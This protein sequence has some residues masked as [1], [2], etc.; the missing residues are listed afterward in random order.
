MKLLINY[1]GTKNVY[2]SIFENGDSNDNTINLLKQFESY[3]NNLK[4]INKIVTT[5]ITKKGTKERIEYLTELRNL[6][7]NFIYFV[8]PR[9]DEN[10]IK[11]KNNPFEENQDQD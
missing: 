2:I 5:P 1:L 6:A 3:L 4:I 10:T 11:T 8:N 9:S 7:L